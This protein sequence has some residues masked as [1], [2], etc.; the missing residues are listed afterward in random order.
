M[1]P[2]NCH[3]VAYVTHLYTLTEDVTRKPNQEVV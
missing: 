2:G 1:T 3:I